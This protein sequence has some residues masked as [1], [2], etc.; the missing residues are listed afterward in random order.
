MMRVFRFGPS[1]GVRV[2]RLVVRVRPWSWR[3]RPCWGRDF[4]WAWV[5][6]GVVRVD[7]RVGWKG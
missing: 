4:A 2:W 1:R 7:W 5:S 3:R 6:V